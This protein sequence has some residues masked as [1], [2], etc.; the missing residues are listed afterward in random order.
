MCNNVCL[1]VP[2]SVG[3]SDT[4]F[5]TLPL[6][7]FFHHYNLFEMPILVRE[8]TALLI[9]LIDHETLLVGSYFCSVFDPHYLPKFVTLV[10][11][12]SK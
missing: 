1:S 3:L 8:P 9:N 5:S 4:L 7:T 2:S 11:T 10:Q 6:S 12:N